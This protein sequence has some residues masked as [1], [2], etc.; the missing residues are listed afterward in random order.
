MF[1]YGVQKTARGLQQAVVTRGFATDPKHQPVL[2]LYGLAARY[3]N[4]TYIAA[5][6]AGSLEQVESELLSLQQTAQKSPQFS[7]FLQNPMI[8]RDEK[9]KE[10]AK[11]TEGK[12]STLTTNLLT[13]MAGNARL[14]ELPK[15]AATYERLMRAKRGEVDAVLIT[16]E[17]LD[18]K[19]AQDIAN[20]VMK[21]RGGSNAK[22]VL[23]TKVD[24]TILGGLQVEI[25]DEVLDLS[26]KSQ[27]E[28]ISRMP[29]A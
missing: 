6:K 2:R 12:F 20:A 5:S 14:S 7:A 28:E 22:V 24:P 13:T 9:A 15:I 16:A 26:V 4:A 27:V 21:G 1:K 10:V 3:A 29:L 17:P 23:K 18:E 19:Q 25:G 8:S 11:L